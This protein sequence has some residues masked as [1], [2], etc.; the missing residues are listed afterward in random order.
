[1]NNPPFSGIKASLGWLR[2]VAK[3]LPDTGL[4]IYDDN[5]RC[6]LAEGTLP[7]FIDLNQPVRKNHN[8]DNIR[9]SGIKES[10]MP[11]FKRAID[12]EEISNEFTHRCTTYKMV[13]FP[14][15]TAEPESDSVAVILHKE[16]AVKAGE[17]SEKKQK[18][19]AVQANKTKTEFLARVSH[20]IRT[21][22][23]AIL[24]FTEQLI[25]TELD[26]KQK[27]FVN[28]IDKSSEHLL[29]LIN[30]L[31]IISKIEARQLTLDKTPFKIGYTLN[32]IHNTLS[33]KADEKNLRFTVD[34]DKDLDRVVI[35]DSFRLRQVL[36]N[37]AS[38]AIKF[39]N[40]GYVEIRCFIVSQ[41][42]KKIKVRFDVIDT[43]IGIKPQDLET[44]F[45][46]FKQAD[47]R[48]TLRYGGTGLGLTIC[49]N[50]IEL[51]N[52]SLS[53]SSQEGIGTTFS[54]TIPYEKGND[55]D[56]ISH[57]T[58][59]I[60]SNK[61][62]DKKV[63]LVDDDSVNRLLGKTILEKFNCDIDI[64]NTG[65]EAINKINNTT[66][67]I[68]LLDIH[69]P[70]IS[71]IEVA[72]YLRAVRKDNHTK[73]IAVTAEA[74]KTEIKNYYKAGMNDFLIKPFKEIYLFNKMCEVCDIKGATSEKPV[75]EII[76]TEELEPK[77]YNLNEL[78]KMTGNNR[79]FF[80][81]MLQTFIENTESSTHIMKQFLS[82]ENW[83]QL[84]ETAHKILP[85]Y[86]HLQVHKISN[87]LMEIKT[88]SILNPEPD[89]LP[90]LI[91]LTVAEMKQLAKNLR[92]EL[93]D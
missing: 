78:K 36:M 89:Q 30:D 32:Y 60:D 93:M 55:S 69:L 48:T 63:L 77:N 14:L 37:M 2:K 10:W 81:Q 56:L 52:G 6:I 85:S 70:D 44:I 25:Q 29:S 19:E 47:S 17:L 42:T 3:H 82:E 4:L 22:L 7:D 21:P 34:I 20:E 67:D 23:N 39:T 43:G 66:F 53:V 83:H 9:D 76:I 27:E 74:M 87:L 86:K 40:S 38:N 35:G 59:T 54:F 64:A 24:G 65:N 11:L 12:G 31:L 58:G 33:V 45:E 18:E 88:K 8:L 57:E 16:P 73:I 90:E 13:V 75:S 72:K 50:L 92:K 80:N 15:K 84:G 49:K 5:L 68:I 46:Q 1:M 26:A 51:Q 61:L 91:E 62:K 79:T 28:I 71:G 41:T